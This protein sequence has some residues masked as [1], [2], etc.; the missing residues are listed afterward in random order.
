MPVR[1]ASDEENVEETAD[2]RVS[3]NTTAGKPVYGPRKSVL[4]CEGS[5]KLGD[6]GNV[7]SL[8]K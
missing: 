8:R 6:G 3:D 4:S 7:K 1:K 2:E 5:G